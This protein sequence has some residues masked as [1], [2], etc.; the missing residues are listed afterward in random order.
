MFVHLM[1]GSDVGVPECPGGSG[2]RLCKCVLALLDGCAREVTEDCLRSGVQGK[3]AHQSKSVACVCV[4]LF[5]C[6]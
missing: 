4:R 3:S 6:L 1:E 2:G 5:V